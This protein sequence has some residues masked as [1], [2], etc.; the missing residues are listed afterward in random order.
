ESYLCEWICADLCRDAGVPA[1]RVTH[2]R[3]W[4]NGRDLGLYVLKE[5]FDKPFL[6]RH[7]GSAAG[8]LYDGGF[9]ADLDS[10]LEKDSGNG[11]D[12]HSDLRALV[13]ACR[14]ADPAARWPA[15]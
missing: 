7:F 11:P 10:N 3:V 13:A 6:V 14:E 8:N 12:D 1:P 15:I 9:C 4:L 2:A 5:G